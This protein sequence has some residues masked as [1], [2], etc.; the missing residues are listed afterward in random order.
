MHGCTAAEIIAKRA[1]CTKPLMGLAS[2]KNNYITASDIVIAKN[3]LTD[4]K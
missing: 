2:F 3:Y 4:I 1:D